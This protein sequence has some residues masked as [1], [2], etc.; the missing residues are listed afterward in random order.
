MNKA[1]LFISL[2]LTIPHCFAVG[3]EQMPRAKTTKRVTFAANEAEVRLFDPHEPVVQSHKPSIK[4]RIGNGILGI[5]MMWAGAYAIPTAIWF[6]GNNSF[7]RAASIGA[8]ASGIIIT[9]AGFKKIE[10]AIR[11]N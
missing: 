8:F 5:A 7:Y 11:G 9:V 4:S 10:R 2:A 1:L 3:N 6:P